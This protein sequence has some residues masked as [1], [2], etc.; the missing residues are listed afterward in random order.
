MEYKNYLN[1]K[2]DLKVY[3]TDKYRFRM[4][5][6]RRITVKRRLHPTMTNMITNSS[7]VNNVVCTDGST[8]NDVVCTDGSTVNDVVCINGV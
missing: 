3:M 4:K 7:K 8:V 2:E 1:L 5:H 6:C